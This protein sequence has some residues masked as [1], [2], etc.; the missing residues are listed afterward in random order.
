MNTRLLLICL[1]LPVFVAQVGAQEVEYK[2][3]LGGGLGGCFY[4][5][6]AN[7][8]PFANL[9]GMF[10]LLARYRFNP[11]MVIKGNLAMGHIH[12][13][14]E[15]TFFPQDAYSGTVEGGQK[16]AVDFSRNVFDVG[17]QFEFN[18]W[19][20]GTGKDYRETKRITPYMLIGMG[21]TFAPKPLETAV[22]FN[23][24]VGVGVKYKLRPR[25]NIGL[26]WSIR[27]TTTDN[28]DVSNAEG[29]KLND[30]YGITSSGF[31]NKDCYSYTMV[32]LTYDLFPKY[33]KCNN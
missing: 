11:R 22:G 13:T 30:P 27:F 18:F 33:R 26:E 28:L 21:L 6:D 4:L 14:G 19:G 2:M 31:K 7:S 16:G 1:S 23:I 24:P 12:G 29:V 10:S 9:G 8:K 32:Y 3:E 20:Y 15:G 5:G 25:L 17:A